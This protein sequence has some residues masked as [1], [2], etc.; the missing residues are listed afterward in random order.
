MAQP[1]AD[2]LIRDHETTEKVF[3]ACV[4]AFDAPEG[5]DRGLVGKML[6]YFTEYVDGC[7]NKKEE[8]HLFPLVEKLGIPREGGPLGMMLQEHEMGRT[9]LG[10][11]KPLAEAYIAGGEKL[12]ELKAAVRE[13]IDLLKNHFWKETDV[14]YPMAQRVMGAADAEAVVKG[15]E[16]TEAAL[17]PDT[18]KRYYDLAA[19][20]TSGAL[21]DLVYNLPYDTIAAVLNTLPVELS[22]VDAEDTVRYFSHEDQE[23]IFPRTRGAIG[24]KVQECHPRKSLPMVNRILADFKAGKRKV[25]EFWIDFQGK[26]VHIRYWPVRSPAG[27][28]LGCLETVQDVTGIR[29]LEGQRRLLDEG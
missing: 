19:E 27:K 20:I 24:V 23:K 11:L 28:Y 2:L 1:W 13:Y 21:K 22:F 3:D 9:L 15:I 10:R 25:A 16:A 6:R 18:R 12:A 14:L 8:Q 29:A 4:K 17:G 5:P 7:H 26:K